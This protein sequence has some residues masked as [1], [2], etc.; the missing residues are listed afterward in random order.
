MLQAGVHLSCE[1]H[2][3]GMAH[4]QQPWRPSSYTTNG[5]LHFSHG[6]WQPVMARRVAQTT[7][8]CSCWLTHPGHARA[9]PSESCH[10]WPRSSGG[11]GVLGR[12]SRAAW[13]GLSAWCSR[14]WWPFW[15]VCQP[16]FFFPKL[17][18]KHAKKFSQSQLCCC[19]V[20]PPWGCT[21]FLLLLIGEITLENNGKHQD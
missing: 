4:R 17:E 19:W 11:R 8:L 2:G 1:V 20:S 21:A 10:G 7:L 9:G 5:F 6:L 3:A 14:R 16:V 12:L 18:L 15:G 13:P